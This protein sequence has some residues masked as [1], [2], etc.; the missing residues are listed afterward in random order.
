M[1]EPHASVAPP[2]AGFFAIDVRI[3]P[4]ITAMGMNPAIAYVVLASGT[5]RTPRSWEKTESYRSF[6]SVLRS[7]STPGS[8][9]S[10]REW[11]SMP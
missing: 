6:W 2:R 10:V 4:T 1:S 8:L 11:R 9:G 3:V 7:R 5:G